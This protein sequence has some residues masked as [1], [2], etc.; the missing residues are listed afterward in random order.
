MALRRAGARSGSIAA[1][2]C[3]LSAALSAEDI[4]PAPEGF[5][6]KRIES[7]KASFLMPKGWYFKEEE[8]Q[9][10]RAFFI[11]REDIDSTGQFETGLTVNVQKFKKDKATV[12]AAQ[13]VVAM[14]QPNEVLDEWTTEAGVLKAFGCRVRETEK[15]HPPLIVHLL[16]I[17]NE[18]TNTLYL[19]LF[20][21]PEKSWDEAWAKGQVMLEKFFLDDEI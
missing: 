1:L 3:A 11:T 6:W 18:K 19:I 20:E 2:L 21:S 5:S 7:V 17:G 13:L 14:M 16:A 9:G 4:P 15:D 10:T 8:K 12:K